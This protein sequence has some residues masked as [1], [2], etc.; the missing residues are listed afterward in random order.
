MSSSLTNVLMTMY[1]H[2]LHIDIDH[3]HT[4]SVS[5]AAL[6]SYKYIWK[7]DMYC[8]HKSIHWLPK[9]YGSLTSPWCTEI[10]TSPHSQAPPQLSVAC[11]MEKQREPGDFYPMSMM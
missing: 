10:N 7:I 11:S 6:S 8:M 9:H 2:V 5:Q 4:N 1:I 3:T